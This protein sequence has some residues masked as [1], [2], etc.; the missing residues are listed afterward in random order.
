ML[1]KILSVFK[2]KICGIFNKKICFSSN[3]MNCNIDQAAA[4]RQKCR[5][6]N[7]NIG[8]YTYIGRNTLIQNTQIGGF[9]SI[10]ESCNIGMPSH[11]LD[12]VSTSPVFLEGGNCLKTHFT[13][14]PYEP[15]PKTEIGSDVWIGAGAMIKSGL[16]VG[17]GAVIAA[18]AVVTRDV[19][20]YAIVGGVPAKIIRYRF[21]SDTIEKLQLSQW[22]NLNDAKLLEFAA[23]FNNPRE[24]A[25]RLTNE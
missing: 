25:E 19:P 7:T 18:G 3:I 9:C 24:A 17:N 13:K 15:C 11:P 16:K 21:D 23:L 14:F 12:F 4:I 8:R 1:K 22:W 5:I 6:Y 10:S 2:W 20:D